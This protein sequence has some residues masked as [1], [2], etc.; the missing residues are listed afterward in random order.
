MPLAD[1]AQI[2]GLAP[3]TVAGPPGPIAPQATA[4]R[5]SPARAPVVQESVF[6]YDGLV[7]ET[8]LKPGQT[9]TTFTFN[10]TN[11]SP[12]EVTIDGVRTSCGCTVVKLPFTPWT[13]PS[14]A[15]GAFDV[16]VDLRGDR[17]N[18]TTTIAV[19]STAGCRYLTVRVFVPGAVSA[20]AAADRARNLQVALGDRQAVFKGDCAACHLAP[21]MGRYGEV[22]YANACG[23]CHDAEPRASMVPDL[24]GRDE[25]MTREDWQAWITVSKPRTLMPA[26]SID[27]G[28]PLTG[29][30]IESL[31]DYV[32]GPFQALTATAPPDRVTSLMEPVVNESSLEAAIWRRAAAPLSEASKHT[33]LDGSPPS[34][35]GDTPHGAEAQPR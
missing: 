15:A 28:G 5:R 11:T 21:A 25:P 22:L 34:P 30:Q 26:W 32:T 18:V 8:R 23:I 29:R 6:A 12:E 14:G 35:T 24:R 27:E 17:G 4:R 2:S 13:I 1:P 33:G 10:L 31:L 20:T 7:K 19:D 9:S 3:A 16:Q